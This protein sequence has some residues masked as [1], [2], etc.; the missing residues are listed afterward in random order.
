MHFLQTV[1][2]EKFLRAVKGGGL[3]RM[4]QMRGISAAARQLCCRSLRCDNVK[5]PA[6]QFKKGRRR[7][8]NCHQWPV[9]FGDL[10][11][12]QSAGVGKNGELNCSIDT[13]VKIDKDGLKESGGKVKVERGFSGGCQRGSVRLMSSSC[14]SSTAEDFCR[15]IPQSRCGLLVVRDTL[16]TVVAVVGG[17]HN[18]A[19]VTQSLRVIGAIVALP[20]FWN[21]PFSTVRF[22]FF[23]FTLALRDVYIQ[24]GF[25]HCPSAA[26]NRMSE[27]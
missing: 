15:N 19:N 2:K 26:F 25:A 21:V 10:N 23:F 9:G 16:A 18:K 7:G 14:T 20:D 13:N 5:P 4:S 6:R 11:T 1:P 3:I 22:F 8:K 27:E 17:K 24:R 12:T